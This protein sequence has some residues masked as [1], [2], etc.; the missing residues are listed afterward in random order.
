MTTRLAFLGRPHW[1]LKE[2]QNGSTQKDSVGAPV[3]PLCATPDDFGERDTVV[4]CF[5]T[6]F[7]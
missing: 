7:V 4:I 1:H 3:N 6:D 2:S 5:L